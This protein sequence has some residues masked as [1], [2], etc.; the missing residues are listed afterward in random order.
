MRVLDTTSLLVVGAGPYGLAVAARARERGIDTVVVGQPLGFWTDHMP[1]GMFLRSGVD[2][3]LDASGIHTFEAFVEERGLLR[4]QLDP[5]P[6]SV[7]L[8]YATWFQAQKRLTIRDQFV[9]ALEKRETRFVASL[10]D[11]SQI[12]AGTSCRGSGCRIL[13]SRSGM[14]GRAARGRGVAH[15]RPRSI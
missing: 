12:S 13:R 3:H 11:G 10:E 14:G 5:I 15:Q 9:S 8:E 6:I 7:F 4:S 2:W 1:A